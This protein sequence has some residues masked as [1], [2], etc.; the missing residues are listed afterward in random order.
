MKNL[1]LILFLLSLFGQ[2]NTQSICF[3]A[4]FRRINIIKNPS[5]EIPQPCNNSDKFLN[6]HYSVPGWTPSNADY[7]YYLHECFNFM[8]PESF[9]AYNIP[10]HYYFPITPQP[11][12]NGKGV[13]ALIDRAGE[14]FGTTTTKYYDPKSYVFSTLLSAF[15]KDSL[16]QLSFYT[17]FGRNNRTNPSQTYSQGTYYTSPLEEKFSFYGLPDSN[18][19]A[20]P[21]IQMIFS[22]AL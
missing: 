16:Y 12:P 11:I 7:V 5:F 2:A 22:V 20:P 17:G 9:T 15:K 14:Q 1:L 10:Y 13:I 21:I 18:N 6:L 8:R 3:K 4:P 19:I